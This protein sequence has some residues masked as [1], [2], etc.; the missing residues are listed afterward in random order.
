MR[1]LAPL[2]LDRREADGVVETLAAIIL[3][4]RPP[5]RRPGDEGPTKGLEVVL[6]GSPLRRRTKGPRGSVAT[7]GKGITSGLLAFAAHGVL[8]LSFG[9][10]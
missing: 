3:V 10:R 7:A 5:R 4:A 1:P 2:I 9:W 8:A 6:P